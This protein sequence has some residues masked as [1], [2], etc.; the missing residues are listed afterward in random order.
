M[1]RNRSN[2]GIGD[3]RMKCLAHRV[4][5][6]IGKPRF[7]FA[8][9]MLTAILG[10][11]YC[12]APVAATPIQDPVTCSIPIE[13]PDVG[14]TTA[15]QRQPRFVSMRT[16]TGTSYIYI[17]DRHMT[18]RF[19]A[20]AVV[21]LPRA[22]RN[23]G[24]YYSN[25]L[26]LLAYPPSNAS[27]SVMLIRAREEHYR[28]QVGLAWVYPGQG[29]VYRGTRLYVVPGEHMLSLGVARNTIALGVDG[30][31]ICEAPYATFFKPQERKYYQLATQVNQTGDRGT[32]TA[33][34]LRFENDRN[35]AMTT[36]RV[37]CVFRGYGISWDPTDGGRATFIAS[38]IFEDGQSIRGFEGASRKSKCET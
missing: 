28:L 24:T 10:F 21:S 23:S 31:Q 18:R 33:R 29:I 37:S 3:L 30:K 7:F 20:S 14:G 19:A 26:A 1:Q 36:F 32:G 25:G 6:P 34:N 9:Y 22:D 16:R 13:H 11:G 5:H 12:C 27:I 15:E 2:A 8:G 38:G 35:A 4:V 17:G